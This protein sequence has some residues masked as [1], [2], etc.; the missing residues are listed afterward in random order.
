[1]GFRRKP[2]FSVNKKYQKKEK[3]GSFSNIF[4]FLL[5]ILIM[6]RSYPWAEEAEGRM[7]KNHHSQKD[8]NLRSESAMSSV[9]SKTLSLLF[10]G[11]KQNGPNN[12]ETPP[13][14]VSCVTTLPTKKDQFKLCLS[15]QGKTCPSC[16]I[17]CDNCNISI[18]GNCSSI[19]EKS[20]QKFCLGCRD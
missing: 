9:Y 19:D 4:K 16:L 12:N 15:C 17:S 3:T 2:R 10:G 13:N 7:S 5:R 1:M 8:E 14:C 11:A 20:S 18:C 6:K